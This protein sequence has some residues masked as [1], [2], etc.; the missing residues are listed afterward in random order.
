MINTLM[1]VYQIAVTHT[2][3]FTSLLYFAGVS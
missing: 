3:A 1:R 2:A